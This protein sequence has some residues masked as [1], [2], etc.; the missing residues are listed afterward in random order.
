MASGSSVARRHAGDGGG[1]G[2]A[3]HGGSGRDEEVVREGDVGSRICRVARGK[4][5]SPSGGEEVGV[6]GGGLS[7]E[8]RRDEFVDCVRGGEGSRRRRRRGGGSNR[9]V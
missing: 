3:A 6:G 2:R 5:F 9:V 8:K 1:T 4:G 7:R